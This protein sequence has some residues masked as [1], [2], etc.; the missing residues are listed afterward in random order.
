[1][2][3]GPFIKFPSRKTRRISQTPRGMSLSGVLTSNSD[4]NTSALLRHASDRISLGGLIMHFPLRPL[5]WI[6]VSMICGKIGRHPGLMTQQNQISQHVTELSSLKTCV[7]SCLFRFNSFHLMHA[8]TTTAF[9]GWWCLCPTRCCFSSTKLEPDIETFSLLGMSK[10]SLSPVL[11]WEIQQ[12][13]STVT[14]CS[15]SGISCALPRKLILGANF[16]ESLES[17]AGVAFSRFGSWDSTNTLGNVF[18]LGQR[19]Y[20]IFSAT[21]FIHDKPR[22]NLFGRIW[23]WFSC[24]TQNEVMSKPA[25]KFPVCMTTPASNAIAL[26]K[27][28]TGQPNSKYTTKWEHLMMLA[29]KR[30]NSRQRLGSWDKSC[31]LIPSSISKV[32]I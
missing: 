31:P 21:V 7:C 11:L 23:N 6:E 2:P 12:I 9:R 16:T 27:L 5:W 32:P 13:L 25:E 18:V 3:R 29:N 19:I 24:Y 30:K 26:V 22:T 20:K 17:H 4:R 28:S 10:A 1:M 8:Q 15:E 14:F